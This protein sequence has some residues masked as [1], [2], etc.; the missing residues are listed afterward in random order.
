MPDINVLI[1][2]DDQGD[3]KALRRLLRDWPEGAGL[4]E[5]S[6]A[7]DAVSFDA[8]V[9]DVVCLDY[10]LPDST[11]LELLP[12]LKI[13]WPQAA[14]IMMTGQGGEDLAKTAILNGAS[15]YIAKNNLNQSAVFRMI[16]TGIET[17]RM[18]FKA[19][20]RRKELQ[21]FAD[22]LVHDFKA[23]IRAVSF[24]AEQIREDIEDGDSEAVQHDLDLLEKSARQMSNLVNS[25]TIHIRVDR[26]Q[27][28]E[29]VDWDD[30]V[31]RA[32]TPLRQ[33]IEDSAATVEVSGGKTSFTCVAPLLAQ[34]VQNL[35]ANSIKFAGDAPP[36][37]WLCAEKSQDQK[38]CFE[39]RDNGIGVAEKYQKIMFEPFRR[40]PGADGRPGT[41]LG[42]ATCKKIAERHDGEIWCESALAVG[43][44][45]FFTL[46]NAGGEQLAVR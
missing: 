8:A 17:T 41:G 12:T 23:P 26:E 46:N 14:F 20:Q 31:D 15:D 43:T 7:S 39:V 29:Q 45:I 3:R 27:V 6:S 9:P 4:Y 22:V 18:Q 21:T 25:L 38:I 11:G 24:L 30:I 44:S 33:E 35:I 13:R 32:L 28:A 36:H 34:L 10:L 16:R 2:D 5:A 19:E 40:T 1:V 37:L 42:L